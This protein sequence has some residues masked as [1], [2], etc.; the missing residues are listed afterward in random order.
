MKFNS[1]NKI[2]S[3]YQE[4]KEK[5]NK[6]I[7]P[8][9]Q[10]HRTVIF[11]HFILLHVTRDNPQTFVIPLEYLFVGV[12]EKND[13]FITGQKKRSIRVTP[14]RQTSFLEQTVK[15]IIYSCIFQ[16]EIIFREII[17][18]LFNSIYVYLLLR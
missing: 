9:P 1:Q 14:E 7:N 11:T 6:L 17:L 3:G 8:S 12:I 2:S 4:R 5:Y 18:M 15:K 10:F 16:S 13:V